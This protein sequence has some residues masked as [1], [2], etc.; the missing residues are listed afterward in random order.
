MK[1]LLLIIISIIIVQ[2]AFSQDSQEEYPPIVTDRPDQTESALTVPRK[3]FQIESGFIFAWDKQDGISTKDIGYN[4]NLF[5]YGLNRRL[6]VRMVVGFAGSEVVNDNTGEKTN[7]SGLIPIIVGFKWNFLYG[8]GPIP[9]LAILSHVDI[10][11]AASKDF[12]D[13]NVKQN[14][15]LAGSW[16]LS[17]V[18]SFGFNIGSIID[19]KE[20]DFTGLYTASLG[21]SIVK[22]MG[23]FVEFYSLV[24]AGEFS[25]N[26]LNMGF[27]FPVR[28]NLQFD[29]SGGIGLSQS[30]ADGF[31]SV[32]FAWRIPH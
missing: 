32:G 11:K 15:I 28:N 31:G 18:F 3:S 14:V 21:I 5:R 29:I 26:H 4:S 24:P 20:Y 17:K 12:N 8:D 9:T 19:W 2:S 6:E 30:A 7:R 23:A 1:Q 27:V 10:P 22:W 16:S 25:K 13:G